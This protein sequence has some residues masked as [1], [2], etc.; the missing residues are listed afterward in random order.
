MELLVHEETERAFW[1]NLETIQLI[2]LFI[3]VKSCK[4][5]TVF[6]KYFARKTNWSKQLQIQSNPELV[7]MDLARLGVFC[8]KHKLKRVILLYEHG[9]SIKYKDSRAR[10]EDSALPF[11]I[12]NLKRRKQ[13]IALGLFVMVLLFP[14]TQKFKKSIIETLS[15]ARSTCDL[16]LL[17]VQPS[18]AQRV[19]TLGVFI[20]PP[21]H[22]VV[23]K[24][25]KKNSRLTKLVNNRNTNKFIDSRPIILPCA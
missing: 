16:S 9:Y 19:S 24:S 10:Q 1:I 20:S 4:W 17:S 7:F 25:K 12:I 15:L 6:V 18:S 14:F 11:R 3:T 2:D 8:P 13:K 23:S 5:G 22:P 21:K